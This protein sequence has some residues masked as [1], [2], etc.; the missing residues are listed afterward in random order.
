MLDKLE[1]LLHL[2]RERHF[3][4]AAEAA[5]VSQ[6]TLSSAV[7][8]LEDQFGVLIVDRGSRFQGF[9]PEGAL[10]LDW[11]KRL[12]GDARTMRREVQQ[13]RQ[14]LVGVLRLGVIPTALPFIGALTGPICQ[15]HRQV[16]FVI[17][18]MPSEAVMK[19]IDNLDLDVG[20]SYLD[21]AVTQRFATC[22]M[23]EERY[24]LLVAESLW[25]EGRETVSW[26]EAAGL[27]LCL[28]TPDMQHRQIVE[29]QLH[30]T[31]AV[32]APRIEA[33]SLI[34]LH[35]HVATGQFASIM[36]EGFIDTLSNPAGLRIIPIDQPVLA[37][38]IGLLTSR[39][40]P[41]P[42]LVAALWAEARRLVLAPRPG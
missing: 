12:V 13:V 1:L 2:A 9:T 5:G 27:P 25:G 28:L 14:G 41:Q 39:R 34:V 32:V 4:R 40:E 26:A 7:K 11:A 20:F 17:R 16:R 23:Y 18:S 31:G 37:N 15:R 24:C 22:V 6:P 19:G 8:S 36:P 3:G 38:P 30:A 29:R 33:N 10:I 35:A 21:E 42:P